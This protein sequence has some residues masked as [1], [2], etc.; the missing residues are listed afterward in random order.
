MRQLSIQVTI[1]KSNVGLSLNK[2]ENGN[3]EYVK[4]NNPIKEQIT[5]DVHKW[6]FNAA[7]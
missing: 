4:D 3:V 6:V 7:K 2:T 1:Y 5:T